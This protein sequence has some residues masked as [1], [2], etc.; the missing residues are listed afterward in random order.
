MQILQDVHAPLATIPDSDD[1]RAGDSLL[2]RRVLCYGKTITCMVKHDKLYILLEAM[3]RLYFPMRRLDT[4]IKAVCE[5]LHVPVMDLT[6]DEERD[7][8]KFYKLPAEKLIS[9]KVISI[10]DFVRVYRSLQSM[11][12]NSLVATTPG[13]V[14]PRR[15]VVDPSVAVNEI[16]PYSSVPVPVGIP[17]LNVSNTNLYQSWLA[18][19]YANCHS[20]G[21]NAN[22]YQAWQAANY[23][24]G[25][26]VVGNGRLPNMAQSH[27]LC[28][29]PVE[30]PNKAAIYLNTSENGRVDQN[31]PKI[32]RTRVIGEV[33]CIDDD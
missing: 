7:F 26:S 27:G 11:L 12:D 1:F 19:N 3:N 24:N 10:D 22:L 20:V 21:S 25:H 28:T 4:V 30:I 13:T 5:N 14:D 6:P 2:L 17:V 9:N 32:C 16:V 29:S 31:R 8:M 18:S 23:A 15:T 33:I